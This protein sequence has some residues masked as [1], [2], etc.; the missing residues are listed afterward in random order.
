[1][2]YSKDKTEIVRVRLSPVELASLDEYA[3][4]SGNDRSKTIRLAVKFLLGIPVIGKI[5]DGKIFDSKKL[6]D[7]WWKTHTNTDPEL[8][9]VE[10]GRIIGNDTGWE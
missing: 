3:K 6:E 7:N 2:K 4:A 1:M 9:K 8:G 10:D 5:E